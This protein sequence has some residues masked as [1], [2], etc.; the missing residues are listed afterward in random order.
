MRIRKNESDLRKRLLE[1]ASQLSS[2]AGAQTKARIRK[3][4]LGKRIAVMASMNGSF[5][6]HLDLLRAN[7]ANPREIDI[8]HISPKLHL[9]EAETPDSDLFNAAS[10]LWSVPVSK[11]FGRRMRYL[12]KDEDNGKLIGIIGLTDPVFNLTPRDAWVGWTSK[13]RMERLIHVMDA[14][15][16]GAMPPYN[17][18]LGGKL[19]ALLAASRE[20]VS[21]FRAKYHSYQSII[22]K[23]MKDPHLVLLTTSSALGRSSLYNRLRLPGSVQY[24]T[25]VDMGRVPTWY[26]QGYGHFHIADRMF[27]DLQKVLFRRKHPYAAGNRFGD[28]PN[29]RIRV[30]RQAALELGI[31]TDVLQHG[32]RRQVYVIPLASNTRA[33]LLGEARLPR[34][35]TN[36]GAETTDY[37]RMRWAFPR[38]ERCPDWRNWNSGGIITN[39]SRLHKQAMAQEGG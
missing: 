34:Y 36:T 7:F 26:T 27:F 9:V 31:N 1:L 5:K 6:R 28:G 23:S 17:R 16:L 12:V 30:I 25:D 19:V 4:H 20:V 22:S 15:V 39:L 8:A 24:L 21:D 10:L 38:S 29:W 3:V 11:G 33:F 2:A 32:I 37:W 13:M 18:I 35:I 14:F